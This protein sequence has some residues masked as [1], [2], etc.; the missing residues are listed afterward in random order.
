MMAH[1]TQTNLPDIYAIVA[2]AGSG[3]RMQAGQNK[4]FLQLGRFPV[5]IRTLLAFESHPQV[6][7]FVVVAAT[8]ECAAMRGLVSRHG[9]A[10]CLAVTA[11]G[12]TRQASVA[13]GLD[14]LQTCLGPGSRLSSSLVLIHDG[15]RCF[16]SAA[17]I[18]RVIAGIREHLACGAA[19]PVKDTIKEASA[20]G[21]VIRTLA[22][23]QLWAMQTP[24]GAPYAL[25]TQVYARAAQ[26]GWQAT[27]DL[28]LLEWAGVPVYLVEGDPENIK[29]TTPDDLL[30]G[31]QLALIADRAFGP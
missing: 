10:K 8:E 30:F 22:R 15:A 7:G 31:E 23:S 13:C 3:S 18:S 4:Q 24:Q 25:L 5:I 19:I 29:L 28:T 6:A 2:A 12:A 27:D 26:A 11:G 17:T 21:Q 1:D 16:V 9:L 14:A 20:D